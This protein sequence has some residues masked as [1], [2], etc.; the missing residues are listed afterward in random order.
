MQTHTHTHTPTN[1]NTHSSHV[2]EHANFCCVMLCFSLRMVFILPNLSSSCFQNMKRKNN[3]HKSHTTNIERTLSTCT[4]IYIAKSFIHTHSHTHTGW[5]DF[6]TIFPSPQLCVVKGTKI[7][8]HLNH[9]S[10]LV[11]SIVL[12]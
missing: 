4:A 7:A 9:M 2:F 6:Q 5:L 11:R 12:Y 10:M 3:H 1:I 8:N